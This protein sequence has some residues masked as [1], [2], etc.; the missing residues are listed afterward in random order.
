MSKR[1]IEVGFSVED[2]SNVW[3]LRFFNGPTEII[4]GGKAVKFGIIFK[5]MHYN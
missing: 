2:P 5:N 4:L 3:G 1:R